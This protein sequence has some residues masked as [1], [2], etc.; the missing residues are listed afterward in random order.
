M[1]VPRAVPT[2]AETEQPA[3]GRVETLR[4]LHAWQ[5]LES[6]FKLP[7]STLSFKLPGA[8]TWVG[9][10]HCRACPQRAQPRLEL[11]VRERQD[12]SA[13]RRVPGSVGAVK[14]FRHLN[15]GISELLSR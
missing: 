15:G 11:A 8:R 9:T 13:R 1:A 3:R 7:E 10:P 2:A 14:P 6:L 4:C 5:G 12:R